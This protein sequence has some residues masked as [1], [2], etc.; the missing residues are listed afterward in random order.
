[1]SIS[2]EKNNVTPLGEPKSKGIKDFQLKTHRNRA[3]TCL[4]SPRPT[5]HSQIQAL[6]T[7][8]LDFSAYSGL[9]I[10][11]MKLEQR[12]PGKKPVYIKP[13]SYTHYFSDIYLNSETISFPKITATQPD[14]ELNKNVEFIT[15][16]RLNFR[17]LKR[18]NQYENK[19]HTL[20][21]KKF[22]N[23]S[24][25]ST[26][27]AY[28]FNIKRGKHLTNAKPI[29]KTLNPALLKGEKVLKPLKSQ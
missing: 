22:Y 4:N 28:E 24:L 14:I 9:S 1:M 29:H 3:L 18:R 23:I 15:P 7:S 21:P 8:C 19:T 20:E 17:R 5:Y 6:N 27:K 16:S 2:L 10:N 26:G 13:T 25:E 11:L 12:T